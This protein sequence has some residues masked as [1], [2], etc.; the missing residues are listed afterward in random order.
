MDNNKLQNAIAIFELANGQYTLNDI[1]QAYRK[2]ASANHPDKGGNTET[3]QLINTAFAEL[4]KFFELGNTT[5]DIN[6]D[7]NEEA[8]QFDFEFIEALKKMQGVIIE[9]CGYWVWLTGDTYTHHEKIKALGFKFSGAKKAWY[10]SPTINTSTYR[11][12]SK[13]MKGIRKEYGSSIIKTEQQAA[14]N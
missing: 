8:K 13:S 4:C 7:G 11:R 1:K 2:L 10:W 6:E 14:I 12:G 3:M 9:V 5:L